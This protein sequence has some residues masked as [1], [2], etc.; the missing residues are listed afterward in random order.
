MP[1]LYGIDFSFSRA[2]AKERLSTMYNIQAEY[3]VEVFKYPE[4]GDQI[5]PDARDGYG[6]TL[7]IGL[8]CLVDSY[9]IM[10]ITTTRSELTTEDGEKKSTS[11]CYCS[12]CDYVVQNHLSINNHF[13]MHLRLSLLCMINSCFHIEHWCNNMWTHVT[14]E[15]RHTLLPCGGSAIKEVREGEVSRLFRCQ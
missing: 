5:P 1:M 13:R 8:Y 15:T 14:K 11:K 12:L 4:T 6:S 3:L 7:M 9:S 2:N 10:R